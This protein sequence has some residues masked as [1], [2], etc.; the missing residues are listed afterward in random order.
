MTTVEYMPAKVTITA[1]SLLSVTNTHWCHVGM[2][3]AANQIHVSIPGF[4]FAQRIPEDYMGGG[5]RYGHEQ[6]AI[7]QGNATHTLQSVNCSIMNELVYDVTHPFSITSGPI[8]VY[9]VSPGSP[10]SSHT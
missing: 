5:G 6:R 1:D 10:G 9:T 2:D 4:R 3:I 8:Y 7:A